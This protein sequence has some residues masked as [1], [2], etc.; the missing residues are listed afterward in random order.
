MGNFIF[1]A[2]NLFYSR[3]VKCG[4]KEIFELFAYENAVINESFLTSWYAKKG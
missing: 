3:L 4:K 2:V 1:C